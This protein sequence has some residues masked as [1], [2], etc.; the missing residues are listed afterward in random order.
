M[1][2]APRPTP[3]SARR[4]STPP[5]T[6]RPGRWLG[7]RALE[8]LHRHHRRRPRARCS[9]RSASSSSRSCS[10]ARSPRRCASGAPLD[11]PDGLPEPEVYAHLRELAA[12]NRSA[13]DE[14]SFLGAGMYDHYVPAV[15]DMLHRAL[16]VPDALH[17]L[18]A[19]DLPGRPAGDVRVP[20]RDL[21]ADRHARLQ[22][23]GLRGP[24]AVAAA[25]YLAKLHNGR[26]ALRRRARRCTRTRSRRCGPTPR[27]YGMERRRGGA[28]RRRHRPA[29]RGRRRST[30]T[31]SAVIFAQPNFLGAVEDAAALS[32]AAGARARG[33]AARWSSPG[34]PDHARHP[35][36][37]R[38]VRRRRRRR[39]GPVARQ[40]AGLRRPV[41]RLLRRAR[42]ATCAACPGGSPARRATST[43]A[44][45]SCSRCRPAS[46]TSAAR[47]RPRTSAPRRR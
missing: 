45:A 12:R 31:P 10:T 1:Q 30:T 13:E 21:R 2:G 22:R 39:R 20:D 3:P 36:A 6:R 41:V 9:R 32:A 4:C 16:G 40:P 38:R 8:P 29:T 18:P 35:R 25:G 23:L 17:A 47:R 11:L 42:G 28:A 19:G 46:S 43:A 24:S 7:W 26:A 15:I 5:P 27:G 14:I 37:A 33:R 44:A 34:R